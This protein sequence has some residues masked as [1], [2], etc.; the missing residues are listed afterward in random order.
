MIIAS[1]YSGGIFNQLTS[2]EVSYGL[3]KFLGDKVI[4]HNTGQQLEGRKELSKNN[5]P[6]FILN[7]DKLRIV[8]VL[9]FEEHE[10]FIIKNELI[11]EAF[12]KDLSYDTSY[13]MHYFD[14][15]QGNS[16][17]K[18]AFAN[19]RKEIYPDRDYIMRGA[20]LVYYS[21]FFFN[22]GQE[23]ENAISKIKFKKEY[24]EFANLVS[25]LVGKFNGCHI[26]RRDHVKVVD[27]NENLF[28]SGIERFNNNLPV[29]VS[30]DEYY[31]PMFMGSNVILIED[32]I[33]NNLKKEF[34]SLPDSSDLS[35]AIISN[36]VMRSSEDFIGT[37]TSTFTGH[38]QRDLYKNKNI[39][40]KFFNEDFMPKLDGDTGYSWSKIDIPIEYKAV[41]REWPECRLPI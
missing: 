26:R 41:L 35:F 21:S 15:N 32:I 8:D 1:H 9:D 14:L 31:N 5:I 40:F 38:I 20:N 4:L 37:G 33:S 34:M 2:F 13:T 30:T 11:K 23:F 6:D 17:D 19:G 28:R 12:S 7:E 10:N 25:N 27:I 22:R 24:Y 29:L 36:L 16:S 39:E 18:E 3:S